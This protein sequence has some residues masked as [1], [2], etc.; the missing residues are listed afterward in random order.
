MSS[1][2]AI[3]SMFRRARFRSPRSIP[4]MEVRSSS[5][6]TANASSDYPCALRRARTPNRTRMSGD[7]LIPCRSRATP[8]H[9]ARIH[10]LVRR[11]HVRY[12]TSRDNRRD[13]VHSRFR[14]F[15]AS[16][17]IERRF[18]GKA[19]GRRW[20]LS[21]GSFSASFSG[22]SR[23]SSTHGSDP[24]FLGSVASR[25]RTERSRGHQPVRRRAG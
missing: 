7:R 20:I 19:S 14:S 18:L 2:W 16:T 22:R 24:A 11:F 17:A 4:P 5:Q 8:F 15:S 23:L 10:P 6:A 1:A 21:T 12:R 25:M 9:A 13:A 3:R